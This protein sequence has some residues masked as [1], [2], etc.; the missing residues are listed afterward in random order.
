M[1]HKY[2][3]YVLNKPVIDDYTYD[4]LEHQWYKLGQKLGVVE[5]GEHTPCIDFDSNH[6]L[7]SY[8]EIKAKELLKLR[9]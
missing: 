6:P 2:L 8:A 4:K 5:E 7:A 3:Y 1:T 9:A